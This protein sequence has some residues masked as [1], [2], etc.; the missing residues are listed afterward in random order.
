MHNIWNIL[1]NLHQHSLFSGTIKLTSY[2]SK[3]H[4]G[5]SSYNVFF[6]SIIDHG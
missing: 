5:V 1:D 2:D 4:K 6:S 3:I